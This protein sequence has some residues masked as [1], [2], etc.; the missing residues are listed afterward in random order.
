MKITDDQKIVN[1]FEKA[2]CTGQWDS[3]Y[4]PQNPSSYP[5][6]ARLQKTLDLAGSFQ[7]KTVLDLG[8]GTGILIPFVIEGGGSYIGLDVSESMLEETRRKYPA[9]VRNEKVHLVSGDVRKVELPDNLDL[10]VGLGFIEYFHHPTTLMSQLYGKLSRTGRLILSFPNSR[11][12]DYL[13]M[14]LLTPFRLFARVI[15][16]RATH[17][18]P[19]K[20]WSAQQAKRLFLDAGFKNLEI[21]CYNVNVLAYPVSRISRRF[22]NFWSMKL[23]YGVLSQYPFFATGFLISAQK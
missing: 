13:S 3:L 17:Q 7:G 21:A 23:E 5:F 18:P 8:C 16:R 10:I 6:I 14:R 12:L 9:Y 15:C 20:L 1:H 22:T 19:R 4:H 11:S 2:A